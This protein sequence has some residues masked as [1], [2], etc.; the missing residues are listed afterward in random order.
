MELRYDQRCV[1]LGIGAVEES[2]EE[3]H[4]EDL[5]EVPRDG[6][7]GRFLHDED[8]ACLNE[9]V[10]ARVANCL[11]EVN[12]DGDLAAIG[13]LPQHG[14]QAWRRVAD[15]G[16]DHGAIEIAGIESA[17]QERAAALEHRFDDGEIVIV[18]ERHFCSRQ[19]STGVI[20]LGL[21]SPYLDDVAAPQNHVLRSEREWLAGANPN[22]NA[23]NATL[24]RTIVFQVGLRRMAIV[25]AHG[26]GFPVPIAALHD[27][28]LSGFE[29]GEEGK[30]L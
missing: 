6:L 12:A 20:E 4:L 3:V 24:A 7:V 25:A 16:L 17:I 23:D 27:Y 26:V 30:G 8:I 5:G 21:P 19:Q 11:V 18:R 2:R 9:D 10:F 15:A 22:G 13:C 14:E 29:A 28:F 1:P